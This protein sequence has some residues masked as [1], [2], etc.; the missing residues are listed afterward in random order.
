MTAPLGDDAARTEP[1]P[2]AA[3]TLP[4]LAEARVRRCLGTIF[5]EAQT[6]PTPTAKAKYDAVSYPL[7]DA[8][9][10]YFKGIAQLNRYHAWRR[11]GLIRF[12]GDP[13]PTKAD[14]E[15]HPVEVGILI[16]CADPIID[17]HD[18]SFW[19]GRGVVA[20][21]MT[22]AH[23]SRYAGGN[24]TETGVT[25]LG[26]QLLK[27][28]ARLDVVLDLSHLSQRATMDAL[29][30]TALRVCATHSNC[31]ALLGGKNTDNWQRHAD[32]D[33][34]A[35]VCAR[36]GV[37]GLNLYRG[38]IKPGLGEAERPTIDDAINHIDHVCQIAGSASHAGLGSDIDGGFGA[39]SL[40]EPINRATDLH[41]LFDGLAT[42]NYSDED[43]AAIAWGNWSR[44]FRLDTD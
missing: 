30:H 27:E 8:Q 14:Q 29:D 18:L 3:V 2:P 40:P 10:A 9:A 36:G 19:V 39:M 37:V 12:F 7:G 22:W 41:R 43:I 26:L 31:R 21:G 4:E 6:N 5:T 16:E 35:T 13:K 25:P 32:D 1:H 33:T 15:P 34:I 23:Q 24:A 44:F 20:I 28:M 17:P 38:F 11:D 42:R